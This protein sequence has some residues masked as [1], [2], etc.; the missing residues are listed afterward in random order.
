M[1]PGGQGR[2]TALLRAVQV[3]FFFAAELSADTCANALLRCVMPEGSTMTND[4]DRNEAVERVKLLMSE[5][6]NSQA[7][8]AATFNELV[9][10]GAIRLELD[11][12]G[13]LHVEDL[14]DL[15]DDEEDILTEVVNKLNAQ[16]DVGLIH[17]AVDENGHL[18]VLG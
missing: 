2:P 18:Q 9:D 7:D 15:E 5:I 14:G 11:E 12:P 10:G 3:G 13:H 8:L 4:A 1:G 17:L 16:V 6:R